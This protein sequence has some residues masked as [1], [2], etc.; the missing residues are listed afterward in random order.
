M[1]LNEWVTPPETPRSREDSPNFLAG[2]ESVAGVARGHRSAKRHAG[3]R[4]LPPPSRSR[5]RPASPGG[6]NQQLNAGNICGRPG[7]D[8]V[9]FSQRGSVS[10][11][12]QNA[13]FLCRAEDLAYEGGCRR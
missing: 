10:Q 13:T 3:E 1:L 6:G 4:G 2:S 8:V 7:F 11:L 5:A 9:G 12:R